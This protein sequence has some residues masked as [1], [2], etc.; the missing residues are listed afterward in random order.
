MDFCWLCLR[1]FLSDLCS[2]VMYGVE[3]MGIS[4]NSCC[5]FRVH[6]V[7]DV[8]VWSY[9]LFDGARCFGE[10]CFVF[11]R[12]GLLAFVVSAIVVME[13]KC[14]ALPYAILRCMLLVWE[15]WMLSWMIFF[16]GVV[17]EF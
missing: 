16:G 9:A 3:C 12:L 15:A 13:F 10:L 17:C 8:V 7:S 4:W 11:G 1:I 6:K 2:L 5:F 14:C